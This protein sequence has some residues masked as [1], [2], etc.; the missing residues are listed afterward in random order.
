MGAAGGGALTDEGVARGG[1]GRGGRTTSA[2]EAPE[3]AHEL[4]GPPS[5][6][7]DHPGRR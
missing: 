1:G 6:R 4:E 3:G 7:S 5:H 2:A